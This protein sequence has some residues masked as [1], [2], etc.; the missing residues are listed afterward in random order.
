MVFFQLDKKYPSPQYDNLTLPMRN[1]F[2]RL[3]LEILH[4]LGL[5]GLKH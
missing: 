4:H 3:N 1:I 2:H 5:S